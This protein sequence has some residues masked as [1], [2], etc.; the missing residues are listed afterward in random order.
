[1]NLQ[2]FKHETKPFISITPLI[3]GKGQKYLSEKIEQFYK[4]GDV[5]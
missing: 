4:R 3:T 2:I 5:A 1:M